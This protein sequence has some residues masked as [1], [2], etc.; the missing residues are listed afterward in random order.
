VSRET[1]GQIA[2]LS[3]R[4]SRLTP[5][6]QERRS[7]R[8][9]A[10]RLLR[11]F[12]RHGRHDLPWQHPRTPYRVWVSEVMLQQTQVATV[13]PYFDRFLRTFPGL[14]ELSAASLDDVLAH[15]SGL[16]YYSRARNLHRA[17]ALCVERHGGGLPRDFD[18][19]VA[20][21]GI[22]RSTAGAILA[23]AWGG[24]RAI[25][26]GNVKR[27]LARHAG[28]RGDIASAAVAARLWEY[29]E[30]LLP[31]ARLADYTQAIMDLGA[32]V[33]ARREPD[34]AQCPVSSDC[35][36]LRDGLTLQLPERAAKR[37]TPRRA[38]TLLLLRDASDRILFERRPPAGVWGGLWS[39]PETADGADPASDVRRRFGVAARE[40][41]RLPAFEHAFTHFRLTVTPWTARVSAPARVADSPALRWLARPD[42]ASMGLPQPVRQLVERYWNGA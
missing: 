26:D 28:M 37:A 6:L 31:T 35:V 39:L 13:I 41:G 1:K 18:A 34:C 24:R 33:C 16:G 27:V 25:V 12:D 38:T 29:A 19:L 23:Q 15:W 36:A 4:A 14:A 21:P 32:G 20:L 11:W 3:P 2:T 9:F 7:V 22:G 40:A 30:S 17:A 8:P 5:L 42:L 10:V